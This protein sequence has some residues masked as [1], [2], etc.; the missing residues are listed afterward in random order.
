MV[1]LRDEATRRLRDTFR[2]AMASQAM[3]LTCIE[4]GLLDGQD[5]WGEADD[6]DTVECW[7]GIFARAQP[8]QATT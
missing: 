3:P 5:D 4:E 6:E 7:W 2:A 1:P 8:A